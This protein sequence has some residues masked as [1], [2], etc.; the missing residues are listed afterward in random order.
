MAGLGRL[1]VTG[2]TAVGRP[3]RYHQSVSLLDIGNAIPSLEAAARIALVLGVVSVAIGRATRRGAWLTVPFSFVW[4]A[5]VAKEFAFDA[6]LRPANLEV[7]AALR[8]AFAGLAPLA[9]AMA[10]LVWRRRVERGRGTESS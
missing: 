8:L 9:G 10:G 4:L 1:R 6:N 7:M 2:H 3:V 5:V